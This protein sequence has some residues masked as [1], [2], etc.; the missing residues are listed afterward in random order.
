MRYDDFAIFSKCQLSG[1]LDLLSAVH[2]WNTHEQY[3]VVFVAVQNLLG[4]GAVVSI[5]YKL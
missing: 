3:L 2:I 1:I 4:I 5:I